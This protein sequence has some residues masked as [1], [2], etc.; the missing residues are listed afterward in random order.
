[1]GEN[2]K[3][4]RVQKSRVAFVKLQLIP[5]IISRIIIR[6]N[7]IHPEGFFIEGV[8]PQSETHEEAEKQNENLFL[9]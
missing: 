2:K 8:E 7:F 1:M 6:M 4:R 9:G 3:K 5:K